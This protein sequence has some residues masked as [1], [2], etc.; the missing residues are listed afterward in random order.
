MRAPHVPSCGCDPLHRFAPILARTA[1]LAVLA[2]AGSALKDRPVRPRTAF[3]GEVG[4]TG[5]VRPVQQLA[6]RVQAAAGLGFENV[7]VPVPPSY[8]SGSRGY[9][10]LRGADAEKLVGV[11]LPPSITVVGVASARDALRYA[12][13]GGGNAEAPELDDQ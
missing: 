3:V 12:L 6:R 10:N 9:V 8:V 5:E 1:D 13:T 7:V 2:A 4:L 11:T